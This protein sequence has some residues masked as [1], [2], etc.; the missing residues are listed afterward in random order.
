M[1][2]SGKKF[3]PLSLMIGLATV[4]AP[5]RAPGDTIG[6]VQEGQSLTMSG[7]VI[8][9]PNPAAATLT[10]LAAPVINPN[11][12][13]DPEDFVTSVI[14]AGGTCIP[15]LGVTGG[16][17]ANGT[18]TVNLRFATPP[19]DVKEEI[20]TGTSQI[21]LETTFNNG[22]VASQVFEIQ[23]DDDLPV[24]IPE[25]ESVALVSLGLVVLV[26]AYLLSRRQ[27]LIRRGSS[28]E[29]S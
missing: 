19:E 24:P 23:V 8:T 25:P 18:C 28:T 2:V 10:G 29:S 22:P 3:V 7:F 6:F 16:V 11:F 15:L 21:R 27:A 17:P 14:L 26:G 20:D 9:N 5:T 1:R 13:G 12:A 4:I